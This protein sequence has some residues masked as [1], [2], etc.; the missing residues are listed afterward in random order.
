MAL[1]SLIFALIAGVLSTLS[2]C[3]LPLLPIVLGAAVSEHRLG[4]VAL[5]GGLAVS[6]TAIGLFVATIGYSIGLDA[7]VFRVFGALLLITIG[8]I[9]LVPQLQTQLAAAAAPVSGWTER[10]FGGIETG[11]LKGQLALGLLLGAVW[12][13]C[14]GPTLGAA[15]VL[16]A[17]GKDLGQVALVMA[18]FGVGAALPLLLLG[19]LSREALLRWRARLME[20]GKGGKILLGGLLVVLGLVIVSGLDKKIEAVLVE[21][22]PAWLTELTTKF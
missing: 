17:Q 12:S 6:F 9:L 2:P 14:V 20:A 4:P 18:M 22:S 13:P 3:V 16:A 7:G 5:S 11:G 15:S 1:G 21:A 8:V 19:L 10:R